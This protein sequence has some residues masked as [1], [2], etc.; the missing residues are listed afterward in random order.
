MKAAH[1][2]FRRWCESGVS[3]RVFKTF[4]SEADAE[5][6]MIGLTSVRAHQHSAG[7]Q[8]KMARIKPSG[9]PEVG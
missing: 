6:M 7:A 1:K 4:A 9:D 5:Y 3:E 2:R 8:K